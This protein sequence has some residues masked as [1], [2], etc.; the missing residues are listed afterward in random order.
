M[1]IVN[2]D[3]LK[4]GMILNSDVKDINGRLLLTGGTELIEKHLCIFRAWG[5]TEADI[6]G[7]T[8]QDVEAFVT[9]KIDPLILEK[10]EKDL[11]EIFRHTDCN[12]PAIKELFRLCVLRKACHA[13]EEIS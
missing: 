12:H 7:L 11:S 8:D 13:S 10:A 9:G 2:I 3:Y 1:A 6:Q 4:P 5:V